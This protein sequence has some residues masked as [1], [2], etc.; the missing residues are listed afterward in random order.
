MSPKIPVATPRAFRKRAGSSIDPLAAEDKASMRMT[1]WEPLSLH[2]D[3]D[4]GVVG[5][6]SVLA[7]LRWN[8]ER[9]L[10][11]AAEARALRRN[12]SENQGRTT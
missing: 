2:D 12:A 8:D 7:S 11:S 3:D 5:R 1:R 9:I 4:E 6:A 10:R